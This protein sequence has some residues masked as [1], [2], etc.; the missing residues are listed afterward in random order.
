[1]ALVTTVAL[2]W[3]AWLRF[4]PPPPAEPPGIG[5]TPPPL[6]LL[7][8]N[9]EEPLVL[10]GLKGRVVWLTFWTA[11]SPADLGTLD[12]VWA[13]FRLRNR[14]TMVAAAVD[15]AA[16]GR[17]RAVVD[18]ARSGLPVYLATPQTCRAFGA[19]PPNLPLHVLI[20]ETGRVGA[21][22]QGSSRELLDRLQGQAERWLDELEPIGKT[23]FAMRTP[24][25]GHRTN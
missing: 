1:M 22:A 18:H 10:L 25:S 16:P 21:V 2:A 20:D 11:G 7:D 8:A 17:V 24:P 12:R 23:R 5:G 6:G 3:G 14:F 19:L 9:T 15:S 13:R 4:G